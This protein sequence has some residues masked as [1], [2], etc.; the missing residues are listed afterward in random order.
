MTHR[1]DLVGIDE[2]GANNVP[3][4]P[5]RSYPTPNTLVGE[6]HFEHGD[7]NNPSKPSNVEKDPSSSHYRLLQGGQ[8]GANSDS[9]DPTARP[10]VAS[11]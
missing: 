4:V 3:S 10:F 9:L 2:L 8:V 11:N 7:K 6:E 5:N 1:G